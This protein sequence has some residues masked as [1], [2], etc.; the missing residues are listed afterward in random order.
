MR[1][2]RIVMGLVT[3]V[4]ASLLGTAPTVGGNLPAKQVAI[5]AAKRSERVVTL[6]QLTGHDRNRLAAVQQAARQQLLTQTHAAVAAVEHVGVPTQ[7]TVAARLTQQGVRVPL[8]PAIHGVQELVIPYRRLTGKIQNRYLPAAQRATPVTGKVIALTFDDGPD[9][10]LTPK[11]LKILKQ[12]HVHAT[13]FQVGKSV[14]KY[15]QLSR[16]VLAAGHELGNHSW[17]HPNFAAVGTQ[18]AVRQVA[19]TNAAIYH[20]T[21]QLPTYVRPPYGAITRAEGRAIAQPIIRWS[22]DSRDWA[23]LNRQKDVQSVVHAAQSGGIVLM[24]DIHAQS[25]AAVPAIIKQLTAKG[26]RFVTVG[27]LLGQ[28]TLPGLEYFERGDHRVAGN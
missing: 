14:V 19:R 1:G 26:Y 25:V 18:Q 4:A 11:L 3:L 28:N 8:M 27:Q 10:K 23:Y 12:A 24:H 13:F 20:A 6:G 17:D 16:A 7:P 22:I 2:T 9:P 15:P 5:E 21:G